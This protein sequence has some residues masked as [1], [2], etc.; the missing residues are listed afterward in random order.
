MESRG[1]DG[2]I[3]GGVRQGRVSVRRL[4]GQAGQNGRGGSQLLSLG[5][6]M[7]LPPVGVHAALSRPPP[8][9]AAAAAGLHSGGLGMRLALVGPLPSSAPRLP[10]QRPPPPAPPAGVLPWL[11]ERCTHGPGWGPCRAGMVSMAAARGVKSRPT[12]RCLLLSAPLG[13]RGGSA[14][15]RLPSRLWP[16]APPPGAV[17]VKGLLPLLRTRGPAVCGRGRGGGSPPATAPLLSGPGA[18][19]R[20]C[21]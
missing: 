8:A 1:S 6:G 14:P 16:G 11:R 13:A 2:R 15:P 19:G 18:A 5:R 3:V 20:T 10:A 21:C 9:A 12:V 17:G 4:G 7:R